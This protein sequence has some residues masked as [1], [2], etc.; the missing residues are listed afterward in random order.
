MFTPDGRI[1]E[2]RGGM[3]YERPTALTTQGGRTSVQIG[4]HSSVS[5][6]AQ[7]RPAVGAGGTAGGEPLRKPPSPAAPTAAAT[8]PVPRTAPAPRIPPATMGRSA[9]PPPTPTSTAESAAAIL[10]E[11]SPSSSRWARGARGAAKA[12]GVLLKGLSVVGPLAE[13][14][15][16]VAQ[17]ETA[18]AQIDELA[19]Q[20]QEAEIALMRGWGL[21]PVYRNGVVVDYVKPK[22]P[23]SAEQAAPVASKQTVSVYRLRRGLVL[24]G[25]RLP[26][27]SDHVPITFRSL[28]DVGVAIF[29]V[30]QSSA[31]R[32]FTGYTTRV[33]HPWLMR[34]AAQQLGLLKLGQ[35]L[36]T[37]PAPAE[38]EAQPPAQ[39]ERGQ[40][41]IDF[42]WREGDETK[43]IHASCDNTK[44]ADGSWVASHEGSLERLRMVTEQAGDQPPP[45]YEISV[46]YIAADGSQ[47]HLQV[48]HSTATAHLSEEG[49][50][51]PGVLEPGRYPEGSAVGYIVDNYW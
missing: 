45:D 37:P 34:L 39:G 31:V 6:A 14:L 50:L 38:P 13:T 49:Y 27:S 15:D 2:F 17:F 42:E 48:V 19:K 3:I 12:G 29:A 35:A 26:L 21:E 18:K 25:E 40:I 30:S 9:P 20:R 23:A 44:T 5:H 1:T 22:P 10:K 7:P 46:L 8:P 28:T 36:Q 16:Y 32:T 4:A 11:T 41:W 33:D 51:P 24:E 43:G 47:S